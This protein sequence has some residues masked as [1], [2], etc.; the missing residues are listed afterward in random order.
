M[1]SACNI[2][3]ALDVLCFFNVELF[4]IV[5]SFTF[6]SHITKQKNQIVFSSQD[7][8]LLSL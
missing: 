8:N 4:F 2:A 6:S 1:I 3:T 7:G 5:Q